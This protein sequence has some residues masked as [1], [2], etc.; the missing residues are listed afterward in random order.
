MPLTQFCLLAKLY[1]NAPA[2]QSRCQ[3]SSRGVGSF[4]LGIFRANFLFL[5][6]NGSC[7][8]TSLNLLNRYRGKEQLACLTSL[9]RVHYFLFPPDETT[10]LSF[11]VCKNPIDLKKHVWNTYIFIFLRKICN[12][13]RYVLYLLYH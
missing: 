2:F 4:L 7:P 9:V 1:C 12:K 8:S 13:V 5:D 6:N 11:V 10:V 3:F